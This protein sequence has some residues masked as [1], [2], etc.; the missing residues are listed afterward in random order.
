VREDL[1]FAARKIG[2]DGAF[3]S[4]SHQS[5]NAD[6]KLMAQPL[7]IGKGRS[8]VRVTNDLDQTF[9]IAQ[10]DK[11]DSAM[12]ASSMNPATDADGPGQELAVNTTAVVGALQVALRQ[13][14]LRN[15]VA[16]KR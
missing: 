7:C 11:N 4:R 10:V 5:G 3:G 9:A 6:H 8:T 16:T 2:I 15:F 13:M 1:D 12:I 14:A